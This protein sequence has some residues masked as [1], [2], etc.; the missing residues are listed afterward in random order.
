M[1]PCFFEFSLKCESLIFVSQSVKGELYFTFK[2]FSDT[3]SGLIP[4]S[5][6][7]SKNVKNNTST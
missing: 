7:V 3:N 5:V 4:N 1:L 6:R 2:R